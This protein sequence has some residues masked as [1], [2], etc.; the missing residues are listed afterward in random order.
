M[1][2]FLDKI[3]NKNIDRQR[4]IKIAA[5]ISAITTSETE[6]T[7]KNVE[8]DT[9]SDIDLNTENGKWIPADCWHNCGGRCALS[10]YVVDGIPLRVKTDDTRIDTPDNPQQRACVRG[11]SQKYHV[12]NSDRLKYPMKRKNWSPKG[13]GNKELR[14]CDEWE[15]ISWDE[16]I[17]YIVDELNHAKTNYGNASIIGAGSAFLN[18]DEWGG[19]TTISDTSSWGSFAYVGAMVGIPGNG[20]GGSNCRMDLRRSETIILI[21]CNPAWSALGNPTYNFYQAKQAGASFIY[22]G[23]TFNYSADTFGARWI[24]VR[25]AQDITLLLAVAYTMIIED[26]P[27]NNPIIDWDFLNRCTYGFDAEHMPPD[28]ELGENF[29]DYILGKY[30]GQPKTP[31]WATEICGTPIEDIHFLAREL[32]KS[33]KVALLW[34]CAPARSNDVEDFPQIVITLGAMGGHLGKPGHATGGAVHNGSGNGGSSTVRLAGGGDIGVPGRPSIWLPELNAA[35]EC[36]AAPEVWDA[37]ITGRY[38]RADT[39]RHLGIESIEERDIDIR[40]I[41]HGGNHNLLN[42]VVGAA[43]GIEAH[44]KVDFVMTRALFFNACAQYSD[45]VLPLTSAWERPGAIR[46]G[47]RDAVFYP[48]QIM[49]RVYECK[50]DY[51]I[52]E[53]IAHALGMKTASELY[54]MNEGMQLFNAVARCTVRNDT[55]TGTEPLV[56]ITASDIQEWRNKYDKHCDIKISPQKGRITLEEFSKAGVFQLERHENDNFYHIHYQEFREDPKA[57]PLTTATGKIEIYSQT[58]ADVLNAM[59]RSVIKP[60][61]TYRPALHGYEDSF[62]DWKNRVKGLY[63]Y[64]M[65]TPHYQ[66]R[67]HTVFDNVLAMQKAFASPCYLNPQDAAEK[68]IADG[69]IVLIYNEYAKTLRPA[70]LSERLMPGT[71]EISHG[72]WTAVDP[73]TGIDHG[74]S[75][76]YISAPIATGMG[77]SGYNTQLV[78]FKKLDS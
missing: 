54:P 78:N 8:E 65:T 53:M 40:V 51:E 2:K 17:S 41:W 23:P 6:N 7:L 48:Q 16:A 71:I 49:E 69:D 68:G 13:G 31:E 30:D 46:T 27:V 19:F 4:F 39:F 52:D 33:K 57:N 9:H 66:K 34:G 35:R 36:I 59:G 77:I 60:Y 63:P 37:I 43:K 62:S 56:T 12:L 5:S 61:P 42:N 22:V 74:G 26:D 15:R 64:Q 11:R 24:R 1:P 10:A 18:S 25:P 29:K 58:K 75:A 76:N 45:I 50:S 32:R 21:G 38:K 72:G 67:A 55:N 3:K 47:N 44:R 73:N 14:G 70:C 20:F 28:A